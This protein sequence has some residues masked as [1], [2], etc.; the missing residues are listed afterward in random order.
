MNQIKKNG[1]VF[2][3]CAKFFCRKKTSV[4]NSLY[5]IKKIIGCI[6]LTL[7]IVSAATCYYVLF[8]NRE[9][10]SGSVP[11][12]Y[13]PAPAKNDFN[14]TVFGDWMQAVGPLD[15]IAQKATENKS[16]FAVCLGDFVKQFVPSQ[17]LGH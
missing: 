7:G 12:T 5:N 17:N 13:N 11:L 1:N 2:T 10:I 3:G 4:S 8:F 15:E 14:I 9:P 16:A 6:F